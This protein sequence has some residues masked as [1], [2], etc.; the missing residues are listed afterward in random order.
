MK[1]ALVEL[2]SK[3]RRI[4]AATKLLNDAIKATGGR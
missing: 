1:G 4:D 3:T 2:Q